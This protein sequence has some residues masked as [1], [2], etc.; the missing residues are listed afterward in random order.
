MNCVPLGLLFT[1]VCTLSPGLTVTVPTQHWAMA[2]LL[3]ATIDIPTSN[4]PTQVSIRCVLDCE[5][6][7]GDSFCNLVF[8]LVMQWVPIPDKVQPVT[9]PGQSVTGK[10]WRII[11]HW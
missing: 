3:S 8:E 4:I 10:A 11:R 2:E 7:I 9:R 5:R 6:F 1:A